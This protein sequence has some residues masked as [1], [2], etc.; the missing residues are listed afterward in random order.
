M[1]YVPLS[2]VRGPRNRSLQIIRP[3]PDIRSERIRTTDSSTRLDAGNWQRSMRSERAAMRSEASLPM[4][5]YMS[6]AMESFPCLPTCLRRSHEPS[7]CL[8]PGLQPLSYPEWSVG[9]PQDQSSGIGPN[10]R[11]P[12]LGTRKRSVCL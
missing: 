8:A 9:H 10:W 4:P 6:E 2:F 1:K 3:A 5:T 11:R 12:C 7:G